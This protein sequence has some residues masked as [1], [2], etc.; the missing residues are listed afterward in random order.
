MPISLS[1]PKLWSARLLAHLDKTFVYGAAF[2][3]RNYEGEIKDAGSSVRI[4]QVGEVTVNDY[5]G[6]LNE[7]EGLNDAALE[8][9]VDQK[10]YFNFVVDDVDAQQS[11]I[12]LVDE[13]SK[14]AAQAMS[15]VRDIF[16]A[17]FH[18]SVDAG[19]LVG[20][21]AAPIVVGFAGGQTKPYDAFLDLTQKLDEA[22]VPTVD[23]RVVL[24]PW[25]IRA[26]KAQFG[27]R[28][29][30]LGDKIALD[31][32]AGSVDGVTI[33]QSN[34]VPNVNGDKYKILMGK[35]YITFADSI[36]K[37]ETYRPERKF[38]TGV[39]G[40][41]VYGAKNLQPKGFAVGTFSKGQISK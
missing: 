22:N 15:D 20:T 29:S 39:K 27:D 25:F 35:D 17:S 37:T 9:V 32:M 40:L 12:K 7:P 14:R 6:T 18:S 10:K 13:G 31:G 5:S 28:G 16:V 38:G 36:V 19:N 4:L 26:L 41:H 24:P 34:N 30:G 2:T 11:I 21:D 33:Y 1:Q 8:L 23:R 3:N